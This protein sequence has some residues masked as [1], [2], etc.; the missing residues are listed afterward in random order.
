MLYV[1]STGISKEVMVKT[2]CML[3]I[4][5]DQQFGLSLAHKVTPVIQKAC[6]KLSVFATFDLDLQ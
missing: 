1:T 6:R 4:C 5:N 2:K 3:H